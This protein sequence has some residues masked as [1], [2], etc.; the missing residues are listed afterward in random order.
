MSYKFKDGKI[1]TGI[2]GKDDG[3]VYDGDRVMVSGDWQGI[4]NATGV[5]RYIP[6]RA[7]FTV[8]F[9]EPDV[10]GLCENIDGVN[11]NWCGVEDLDEVILFTGVAV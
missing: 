7:L 6:E 2:V 1:F 5:V 3:E 10:G 11:Y 4:K 9:D 8:Y